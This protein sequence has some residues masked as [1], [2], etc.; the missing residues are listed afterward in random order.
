MFEKTPLRLLIEPFGIETSLT[1]MATRFSVILLIEP[2]GI[3]T[4][5]G[6]CG[7]LVR[8]GF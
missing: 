8:H 7:S 2:F 6:L 5:V 4:R 3:E 1:S